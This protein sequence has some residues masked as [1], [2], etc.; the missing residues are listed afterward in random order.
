MPPIEYTMSSDQRQAIER[1]LISFLLPVY[2][3]QWLKKAINSIVNQTYTHWELVIINDQSPDDIDSIVRPFLQ[4]QCKIQYYI[5]KTN[6]GGGGNLIKQWEECIRYAKGDFIVLAGDDDY[7]S[8]HFGERCIEAYAKHPE[9]DIVR[10]RIAFIDSE[11]NII[12]VDSHFPSLMTQSEYTYRY[13]IGETKICVGNL[14]IRRSR[15]T[16]EG[17]GF[18]QTPHALGS[19]VISSI[20][21]AD[22]GI[23]NTSEVLYFFRKSKRQVSSQ[24]TNPSAKLEAITIT[25]RWLS[26]LTLPKASNPIEAYYQSQI[27]PSDWHEKCVYDY[28]NQVFKHL[29]L[30]QLFRHLGEAKEATHKEKAIFLLRRLKDYL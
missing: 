26:G 25:F 21:F 11:E 13:R 8:P 14:M 18:I 29:S 5:N 7:Y 2:K 27:T 6:I 17:K 19:D 4:N 24:I 22:H 10:S 15:F 28:Y 1:P 23:A 12:G 9:V 16:E 30:P 3:G 20:A